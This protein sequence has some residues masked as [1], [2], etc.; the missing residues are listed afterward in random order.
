MAS[1]SFEELSRDTEIA[2]DLLERIMSEFYAKVGRKISLVKIYPD[3]ARKSGYEGKT[4][5]AFR[6]DRN[7]KILG[8]SVSR[9]S[10]HEILDEAALQAVKDAG[11]Y[12][13]IPDELNKSSLNFQIPI[14]YALR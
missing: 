1:V 13:P 12:P 14:S 3:F 7:G 4:L 2:P 9:S 5:I 6:I 10:G 11:P 8:L